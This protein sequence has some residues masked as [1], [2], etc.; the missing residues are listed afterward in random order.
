MSYRDRQPLANYPST[1]RI[2]RK[3]NNRLG[4]VYQAMHSFWTARAQAL[5]RS[6]AADDRRDAYSAILFKS[7]AMQV[8]AN[9]F[10]STPDELLS[11]FL[12]YLPQNGTN[13]NEALNL[14][15]SV[16]KVNWSTERCVSRRVFVHAISISFA[17]S[18]E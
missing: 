15:Q 11:Q 2:A 1:A 16:M 10:H 8:F 3:Q 13:F 9:D 7:N 17:I 14:T 4:A 5:N 18:L 6:A 12:D